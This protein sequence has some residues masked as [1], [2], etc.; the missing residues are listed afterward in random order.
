M[1][2]EIFEIRNFNL[3]T[4][5]TKSDVDIPPDAA[6]ES[7]DVDPLN[8]EGR[9]IGRPADSVKV[10]SVS[11]EEFQEINRPAPND[12]KQDVIFVDRDDH[13]IK[14]ISDFY[15]DSPTV[16]T[17]SEK[18]STS[19]QVAMTKSNQ[20]VHIGL[21]KDHPPKWAGYVK[22][23]F[24]IKN[25]TVQV[26]DAELKPPNVWQAMKEHYEDDK[27][28]YAIGGG[29]I[30][31]LVDA[32]G[33]PASPWVENDVY[34]NLNDS[35]FIYKFD[36]T[37]GELVKRSEAFGDIASIC[38]FNNDNF[39][40]EGSDKYLWV[41]DRSGT[42]VTGSSRVFGTVYK[43][44]RLNFDIVQ[45]NTITS[46]TINTT[47]SAA[48]ELFFWS[49]Q[50][51]VSDM[52]QCGNTLWFSIA[53]FDYNYTKSDALSIL[54]NTP[55]KSVDVDISISPR[56]P[57]TGGEDSDAGLNW[58]QGST[59]LGGINLRF[60]QSCL[61][62]H[63]E[64]DSVGVLCKISPIVQGA[65]DMKYI[66]GTGTERL[67]SSGTTDGLTVK[68]DYIVINVPSE[69]DNDTRS[70]L[71]VNN[72][73]W[74]KEWQADGGNGANPYVYSYSGAIYFSYYEAGNVVIDK[75]TESDFTET[76][77]PG[78][79]P[80]INTFR[81]SDFNGSVMMGS[82]STID[83]NVFY[84]F[85]NPELFWM[86]GRL[87]GHL[88]KIDKNTIDKMETLAI[89]DVQMIV[90]GV[91]DYVNPNNTTFYKVSYLYDS[92]QESPLS[93]RIASNIMMDPCSGR[94]ILLLNNLDILSKRVTHLNIYTSDN[95]YLKPS[96]VPGLTGFRKYFKEPDGFYRLTKQVRLDKSWSNYQEGSYSNLNGKVK[97]IID[98]GKTFGSYESLNDISETLEDT[99][100]NY[101]MSTVIN[102]SNYIAGC[103]HSKVE[104]SD[105]YVF[106]SKPFMYDQF[107]W[108]ENFLRLENSPT[109]IGSF[110]GRIFLFDS[111]NTYKVN[112]QQFY[113]EDT[114]NGAGCIHKDA[115]AISE[116]G[117]C[118][119]DKNNIYLH[120]GSQPQP[121]GT[122]ILRSD[123]NTGYQ[124]LLDESKFMPK[125]F[126]DGK[127]K[128]FAVF[129][130]EDRIW[131]YSA[132][133]GRWDMWSSEKCIGGFSGRNGE[134]FYSNGTDLLHQA[135][136][137]SKNE[138]SFTSKKIAVGSD[139][140]PKK[141][142]RLDVGYKGTKPT[143]VS[144]STDGV[145]YID[146]TPTISGEKASVVFR[147]LK[148]NS[149]QVK[150]QAD[151]ETEIES[152]GVV[153]RRFFKLVDVGGTVAQSS[154]E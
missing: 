19:G 149:M 15:G 58:V 153:Y 7:L 88:Y 4:Y 87:T 108:S 140:Q 143:T 36:K 86:G 23:Q 73:L 65:T 79:F 1:A 125:I 34:P 16:S 17:L 27:F 131:M 37:T 67:I 48:E 31:S 66:T 113:I 28:L 71:S 20:E 2:K 144:Y 68:G 62:S 115:M 51:V 75:F 94:L 60:P 56:M 101:S 25:E 92:Y 81:Y 9:L 127:R 24:G 96:S 3:G 64:G 91:E 6:S 111:N 42:T 147:G 47:Y 112:P 109:A 41:F 116:F 63:G 21:G 22:D 151:S 138:F 97:T 137:S 150:I 114:F 83:G 106:K 132:I 134:V 78:M 84:L 44:D 126:F 90:E 18:V 123:N 95:S 104:N 45:T 118:Y 129:V 74:V 54:W 33:N 120:N 32:T 13:R 103:S 89:P 53:E 76:A 80:S 128:A 133:Q 100:V 43:V 146:S 38:L 70:L 154:S 10:S 99:S 141:F 110:G 50:Y 49:G 57:Y 105:N 29:I 35:R 40:S 26:E 55:V 148:K 119:A 145:S 14:V 46:L 72:P 102:S 8:R 107:D 93:E 139:T 5:T 82:F 30:G 117:L 121:I 152:V 77:A 69:Q 130:T 11:A 59:G 12:D 136:G 52:I 39:Y 98:T 122:R 124:E 142:Y 61:F 135:G 85:N